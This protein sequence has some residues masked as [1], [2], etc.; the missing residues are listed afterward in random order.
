MSYSTFHPFGCS[1][2]VAG[3][4]RWSIHLQQAVIL[5]EHRWASSRSAPYGMLQPPRVA[6]EIQL[7]MFGNEGGKVCE[8]HV[9]KSG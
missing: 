5:S 3:M 1:L 6:F 7:S 8:I 4:S 9:R 2:Y